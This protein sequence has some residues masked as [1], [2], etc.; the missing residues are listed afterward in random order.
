MPDIKDLFD[1]RNNAVKELRDLN[2]KVTKEN[3]EYS[4]DENTKWENLNK[5]IDEL[6]E[7]IQRGER[8]AEL[9]K[10][11]KTS[12]RNFKPNDSD[13]DRPQTG[14]SSAEAEA[15]SVEAFEGARNR[16]DRLNESDRKT[17]ETIQ[18]RAFA[19]WVKA[20][21]RAV[22]D[23]ESRA[24]QQGS[25]PDG[26]YM[27][28]PTAWMNDLIQKKDD[29]VFIRQYATKHM[30]T[31]AQ[32]MGA[33]SLDADPADSDWTTELATGSLDSAMQFGKREL[34]V[35]PLAKRIKVS[36]TLLRNA[37]GIENLVRE[38]LAYKF[39]I[40]EEKA[41]LTGSGVQRP[42]GV[43]T[44][45]SDGISTSRDEATDNTSTAITADGLINAKYKLKAAYWPN[46]RWIFHRDAIKMIRKL[47]DGNSQY[48]WAPGLQAGQPDTILDSPFHVSEYVPNTFTTGLYVG[49][50][51]DFSH[52]WILD[53]LDMQVQR[54][55]EL[56]AET[57]QV[58]FIGR[59]E[60]DA[61]PV[62]EEAFTRVKLG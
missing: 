41:F 60:T 26:G 25:G 30:I 8:L 42:L 39:G 43:F 59:A 2:D 34:S 28:A 29:Q 56:Y 12:V 44:A 53:S 50:I 23:I 7:K 13:G 27:V 22:S 46:A 20:G 45:S 58:G 10:L 24:L 1:Q 40:T 17:I 54:L 11:G 5:T 49:I 31:G 36:K 48:V 6:G 19:N 9:E 14:P 38:R 3:R 4:S 15:R 61:M 21:N 57:N 18:R 37:P 51:G 47:V 35:H 62:L 33:P 55:E 52:Y 32:S 16:I